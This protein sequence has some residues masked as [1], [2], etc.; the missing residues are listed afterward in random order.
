M[1]KRDIIMLAIGLV[2]GCAATAAAGYFG[3]YRKYIPL[4][5]L[6]REIGELE[7]RKRDLCRQIDTISDAHDKLKKDFEQKETEMDERLK[8]YENELRSSPA[9][10]GS[11]SIPDIPAWTAS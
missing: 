5:D 3:V 10:I 2:T 11:S 7:D 4:H 8:F 1:N 6:E 9:T